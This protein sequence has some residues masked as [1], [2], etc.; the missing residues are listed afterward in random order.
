MTTIQQAEPQSITELPV[1]LYSALRTIRIYPLSN[2]Q[3]TKSTDQF[4]ILLNA[5]QEKDDITIGFSEQKILVNGTALSEKDQERPQVQG[6][7]KLLSNLQLHTLTFHQG[8]TTQECVHFLE[9]LSLATGSMGSRQPLQELLEKAEIQSVSVDEKR[10]VAVHKGDQVFSEGQIVPGK[11]SAMEAVANNPAKLIELLTRHAKENESAST[12]ENTIQQLSGNQL[13]SLLLQLSA[14]E[15]QQNGQP[16]SAR[17][18][19]VKI[20]QT[21]RLDEIQTTKTRIRNAKT[22]VTLA[23]N[24]TPESLKAQLQKPDRAG[25]ILVTAIRD[26]MTN[27]MEEWVPGAFTSL[28]TRYEN[29]LP[30]ETYNQV[31]DQAGNQLAILQDQELG[32]VLLQHFQGTF[33]EQLYHKVITQMSDDQFERIAQKLN[34]L[35]HNK[36]GGSETTLDNTRIQAAYGR[37]MQSI[38][39]EQLQAMLNPQEGQEETTAPLDPELVRE[40]IKQ[41]LSGNHTVLAEDIT[42]QALPASINR[43][44]QNNKDEAADKLLIQ[45]ITGLQNDNP[46]T[47]RGSAEALGRTIAQ[48]ATMGDWQRLEKLLPAL[49]QALPFINDQQTLFQAL[50]AISQ[51]ARHYLVEKKYTS[52][53]NAVNFLFDLAIHPPGNDQELKNIAKASLDQLAE[54]ELLENLLDTIQTDQSGSDNCTYLL[55]RMGASAANFLMSKLSTSESRSERN[56]LINLIGEIGKPARDALLFQLDR[57]APWYVIRNIIQLFQTVGDPDCFDKIASFFHH[58]D[59]RV[60]QEVIQTLGVIGGTKRKKFF[61]QELATASE[62]IKPLLIR[63]LGKIHDESIVIPLADQ[64]LTSAGPP[65]QEKEPLQTAICLAL[66]RLG[67]KKALPCL[68]QVIH[69]KKIPG[70]ED[71]SP[72]VLSAAESALHAISSESKVLNGTQSQPGTAK[73]THPARKHD[74]LAEQE[75]TIFR[76]AARGE[77]EE[78]KKDLYDLIVTCTMNKDF[79]NAERLRERFYEIDPM[80]LTEIVRSGDLIEKEKTGSVSPDLLDTWAGLLEN[81]NTVEFSAIYHELK[82]RTFA[83]EEVIIEQGAK[84][85][86]LYFINHGSV[87]I[88]YHKD[89][90]DFFVNSLNSGQV[91]GENFFDASL[92]TVTLTALT[93]V[94]ISVLQ[95]ESFHRWQEEYPGLEAKLQSFYNTCNS[96]T[97]L[98]KKKGLDRR[99]HERFTLSRKVQV[100]LTDHN[101]N[102]IGRGFRGE[103]ADI[104]KGG[105][106]FLIRISRKDNT[107]LLLGRNMRITIPVAGDPA[108]LHLDGL[109][110]SIQPL[111]L[112]E[113]EFSVHIKFP[114]LLYEDALQQILG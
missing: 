27:A 100:Q 98:L 42:V 93:S 58:Q 66:A 10:Y 86:E 18:L 88:S 90:R 77:T 5:L 57:D 2:P 83:P 89:G 8:F 60:Q 22:L 70:L 41:L 107:R 20:D 34:I 52:A 81:L 26:L 29:D 62:E 4:L 63:Q 14:G 106:A 36:H 15:S 45:M 113:S 24:P 59:Q 82:Q 33:G 39:G 108:H 78:A 61:L 92:W 75:V 35:A 21:S 19:M 97:Q 56:L 9:L 91:A 96:T 69:T 46:E 112:L 47:K 94:K 3:V 101:R 74:P 84:N 32:K 64:L 11:E 103:L 76:K 65:V 38:R 67:S 53:I 7:A 105:L 16:E 95:R 48:L 6:L 1:R 40:N 31:T 50:H 99:Q 49:A 17:E 44:L 79:A 102:P 54:P 109:A 55:T 43:L 85:D 51:L 25:R 37:L 80:A 23:D 114:E 110:I 68:K 30:P 73:Q 87:K 72:K 111:Q 12:L 28:L 104:S 71:Y 13:E